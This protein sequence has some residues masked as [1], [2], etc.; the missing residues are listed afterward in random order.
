MNY[1]ADGKSYTADDGFVFQSKTTGIISK[2]L[3]LKDPKMLDNY[4]IIPEPEPI[5]EEAEQE[6]TDG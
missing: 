4:D 3:R 5:P 6:E 2:K 1:T